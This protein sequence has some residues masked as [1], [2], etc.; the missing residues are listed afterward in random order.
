M[1]AQLSIY[2]ALQPNAE[3]GHTLIYKEEKFDVNSKFERLV[4]LL[5]F[6]NFLDFTLNRKKVVISLRN[7]LSLSSDLIS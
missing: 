5:L 7:E 2:T 1:C 4:G 3:G 6:S